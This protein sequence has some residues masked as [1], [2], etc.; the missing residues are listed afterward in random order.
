[1]GLN[2]L[3]VCVSLER[4][5]QRKLYLPCRERTTDGPEVCTSYIRVG[6]LKVRSVEQIEELSPKIDTALLGNWQ[7]ELLMYGEVEIEIVIAPR[8]VS[9]RRTERCPDRRTREANS[10]RQK[11]VCR[12]IG[13]RLTVHRI[14][15]G[16]RPKSN[17]AKEARQV[18]RNRRRAIA[19]VY[20]LPARHRVNAV[21]GPAPDECVNEPV[22]IAADPTPSPD[23]QFPHEARGVIERLVIS[24][25]TFI[26]A[27]IVNVLRR[28]G[29]TVRL[30]EYLRTVVDSF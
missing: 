4:Q 9:A 25:D 24:T 23:R 16:V 14:A 28:S 2:R 1:M 26:A 3:S 12:W 29:V 30:F 15:C 6:C 13:P 5:F 21:K 7:S 27:E 17:A 20:R 8:D 22:H 19:E 11:V 10:N 18:V